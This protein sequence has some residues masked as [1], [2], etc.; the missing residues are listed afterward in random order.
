M[1][2][3]AHE[4]IAKA[5]EE[6]KKAFDRRHCPGDELQVGE[7]VFYKVPAPGKLTPRFRGPM[8]I[9]GRIGRDIYR[10]QDLRR[11]GTATGLTDLHI[12]QLRPWKPLPEEPNGTGDVD[13]EDRVEAESSEDAT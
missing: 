4:H 13:L 2:E 1:R 10:V 3:I 11:E 12:S 5:Q 8:V 7:I 9:V 6:M